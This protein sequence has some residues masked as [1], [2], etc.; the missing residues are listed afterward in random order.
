MSSSIPR[1]FGRLGVVLVAGLLIAL[2]AYGLTTTSSDD[3]IDQS[4]ARGHSAHAPDFDLEL[5]EAGRVPPVLKSRLAAAAGD[6][7]IETT[8]LLGSAV[9]LNFWASWC[10]PCAQEGRLLE[11]GWKRWQQRSVIFV[12]L[13]M[14]DLR[15]DARAFLH[16]HGVDYPTIRDPGKKVARSYGATGIPE[17]YFISRQGKVVAHCVGVVSAKQLETGVRAALSRT[18]LSRCRGGALRPPR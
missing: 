11:Q 7:R 8:E 12:G 17:T 2:L 3:S 18:P 4:L 6:G 16:R 5:L 10:A 1:K 13:D 9:V 14:Q 15:G